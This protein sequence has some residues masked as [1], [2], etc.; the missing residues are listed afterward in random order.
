[1]TGNFLYHKLASFLRYSVIILALLFCHACTS[2]GQLSAG[3]LI[4]EGF[5]TQEPW[6][7]GSLVKARVLPGS[8]VN[9]LDN[10][11]YVDENGECVLGL[12]RDAPAQVQVLVTDAAGKTYTH[13]FDV[14]QRQYDIQ[15]VEGVEGKYVTPN[16][17]DLARIDEDNALIGS[18][19]HLRDT[20]ADY[21]G[22][23]IWPLVG[24]ISGV[25]GSQRFYNGEGRQPHYGVDVVAPVGALVQAPAAGKVTFARD[26]YY[27]G[28]TLVIDHGQGLSSSFLHLSNI[29]VKVGD[30]V[31]QGDSI[32]E[33]GATG[34]VT[35][36]HLDWRMNWLNQRIDPQLLV[37]VM[38]ATEEEATSLKIP[39]TTE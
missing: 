5:S 7:Q 33:V 15:R 14:L 29:L 35:G 11:V 38:P 17:K 16:E 13:V 39:S 2:F 8:Q 4:V 23:F 37:P 32:A 9:F 12:G 10:N 22:G 6:Q 30:V 27:S 18:A 20:R 21:A 25:Y 3:E 24:P 31:K 34:R 26:M 19:R 1:M 36:A 28:W